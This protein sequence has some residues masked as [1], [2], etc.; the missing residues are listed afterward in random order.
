MCRFCRG[1]SSYDT[2]YGHIR[3]AKGCNDK[4]LICEFNSCPVDNKYT[5]KAYVAL[6]INFCPIC[7]SYIK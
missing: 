1:E 3:I 2:K 7:G 4:I 6:L 5:C